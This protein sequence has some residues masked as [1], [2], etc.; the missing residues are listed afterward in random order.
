MI[1]VIKN[2]NWLTL[3][4]IFCEQEERHVRT[5]PRAI[6]RKKAQTSSRQ[7]KQMAVAM[8]HQFIRFFGCRIKLKRMINAIM[9]REGHVGIGAINGTRRGI[10]KMFHIKM[11]TRL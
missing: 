8:R 9:L 6:H 5:P 3:D 4:N 10:C 11:T 1:T 7:S 2:I